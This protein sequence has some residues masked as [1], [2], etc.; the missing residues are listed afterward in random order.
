M[1]EET[2]NT[3]FRWYAGSCRTISNA[4]D[5]ERSRESRASKAQMKHWALQDGSRVQY[6]SIEREN[7]LNNGSSQVFLA[8]VHLTRRFAVI[9]VCIELTYEV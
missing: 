5:P 9:N 7:H 1:S 3:S 4:S 8:G 6:H 2:F